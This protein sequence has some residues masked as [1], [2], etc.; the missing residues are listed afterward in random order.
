MTIRDRLFRF[1]LVLS[2]CACA[3]G[4][5]SFIVAAL[6]QPVRQDDEVRDITKDWKQKRPEAQSARKRPPVYSIKSRIPPEQDRPDS[7]GDSEIG[8][9]I[10]RYRP[11]KPGDE[12]RDL[13]QPKAGSSKEEWTSERLD[14]ETAIT[15]G[16]MIRMTVESLRQGYLYIIDRAKYEDGSYGDPYMIFPTKRIRDGS[17]IVRAGRMIQIPGANDNPPYFQFSRARSPS[18]AVEVSEELILLVAKQPIEGS[19]L[20]LDRV[21]LDQDRVEFLKQQYGAP[22]ERS[23]MKGGAGTAIT[24]KED[25]TAKDPLQLLTADDPYPQTIYRVAAKPDDPIVVIVELKVRPGVERA[26]Q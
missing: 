6:Q 7:V 9:T 23:E 2:V 18:G 17:N 24:K 25:L 16:Q 1:A 22:V 10:W 19:P 5:D 12:V 15:D 11:A 14:G 26:R 13:I 8:L 21:K 4:F 3:L 20:G